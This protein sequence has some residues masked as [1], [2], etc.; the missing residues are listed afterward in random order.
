MAPD[1]FHT[2]DSRLLLV[3]EATLI[4]FTMAWIGVHQ[5]LSDVLFRIHG[6]NGQAR[7]ATVQA[8][9]LPGHQIIS[10]PNF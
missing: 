4:A 7:P 1:D 2:S 3:Q 5:I 10:M 9:T 8:G 6:P